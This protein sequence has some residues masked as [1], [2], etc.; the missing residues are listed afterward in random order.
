MG[1]RKKL[2]IGLLLLT[3][4]LQGAL[5]L[6]T[7]RVLETDPIKIA[8]EAVDPDNDTVTI[9]YSEP[10]NEEGEWQTE[11]GDAGTYTATVTAS[12]GIQAQSQDITIIV[13][14]KNRPPELQEE[15]LVV[16]EQQTLDLKGFVSDP[17]NDFLTYTFEQ[18]FDEEGVWQPDFAAEGSFTATFT[19]SDGE[20]T[21]TFNVP[22]TVLQTNQPPEITAAFSDEDTV[23]VREGKT[24]EFFVEGIDRD[25]EDAEDLIYSWTLD[26]ETLS[27]QDEGSYDFTYESAGEH[28]LRVTISDGESTTSKTW[29]LLVKNTNRAPEFQLQPLLAEEGEEIILTVPETD[30]DGDLLA[31]QFP[32]P[33]DERG[34]WQTS[35]DEAGEYELDI[36]ASDGELSDMARLQVTVLNVDRAPVL[37]LPEYVEAREGQE[38]SWTVPAEDPDGDELSITLKNAPAGM[39]IDQTTRTLLWKPTYEEIARSGGFFSNVLNALR[40]E[41]FFLQKKKILLTIAVCGSELCTEQEMQLIISNSNRAPNRFANKNI[42]ILATEELKLVPETSDPDGDLVS[43]LFSEPLG[44]HTGEWQTDYGD[45]GMYTIEVTATDGKAEMTVPVSITVLK[46]NRRPTL[47]IKDDELTVTEGQEV[48]F[49]VEAEDSDDDNLTVMARNLP[50]GA[51]FDGTTFTWI[52]AFS[53]VT[54]RTNT[55]WNRMLQAFPAWNTYFSPDEAVLWLELVTSDGEAET[56]HPVKITVKNKNQKPEIMDFLPTGEITPG[57]NEPLLFHIA[58]KDAD[59][60]LLEYDWEFSWHEAEVEGTDTIERTFLTSGRKKVTVTVSDGWEEVE[61]TWTV[62]VQDKP[63]VEKPKINVYVIDGKN[64]RKTEVG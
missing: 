21:E 60:D 17:N 64:R 58:A 40:L 19:V 33:F 20:F 63:M 45:E 30:A 36:V 48:S 1:A 53:T 28:M 22:I 54:T 43:Y 11:Y 59:N 2:I 47:H 49:A 42:T 5:A 34:V 61:K 18:P 10:L 51:S 39:T 52:P 25:R 8:V 4:L 9:T 13:E 35:F 31:Y 29:Q 44:T 6:K 3:L 38:F 50:E 15:K 55:F 37:A 23:D 26:E 24:L 56:I 27:D 32:A 46:K 57:V 16:K 41:H 14:E 7:F 62:L 12:D